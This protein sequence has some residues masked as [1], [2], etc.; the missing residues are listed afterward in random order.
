MKLQI[1]GTGCAKCKKLEEN[2]R[3]ATSGMDVEIE[4]VTQIHDIMKM[5]VM[6]TPAL[7]VDG[8]V[9]S[10]GKIF[11]PDQIK[12]SHETD[13]RRIDGHPCRSLR[14]HLHRYLGKPRGGTGVRRPHDSHSDILRCGR[15]GA[16][17]S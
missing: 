15:Q 4:K 9:V 3:A 13:P 12:K 10:S 6:R 2:A 7:A 5:G 17:S 11:A 8:K 14:N 16:V 1:L